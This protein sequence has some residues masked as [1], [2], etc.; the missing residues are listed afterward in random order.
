MRA[1][2]IIDDYFDL[3]KITPETYN[4]IFTTLERQDT[5]PMTPALMQAMYGHDIEREDLER[6]QLRVELAKTRAEIRKLDA[7]AARDH[8]SASRPGSTGGGPPARS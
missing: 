3:T 4:D 7:E 2:E 5:E 8:A 1:H 6:E